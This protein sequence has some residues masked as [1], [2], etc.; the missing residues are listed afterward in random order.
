MQQGSYDVDEKDLVVK[1]RGIQGCKWS[2][3][4]A[5]TD[6]PSVSGK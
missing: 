6:L 2:V 1:F 5:R 3:V 4:D